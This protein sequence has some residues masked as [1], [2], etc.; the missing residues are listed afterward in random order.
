MW[1]RVQR[2]FGP[3]PKVDVRDELSFHLEMR[4]RELIERGESPERARELAMRRFG[5]YD[6]SRRECEAIDE[7][8]GRRMARTEYMTE[9][10][11]DIGYA[12]RTLRRTP[13]F[14]AVAVA[15][16]AL[17]IG[18][19]SAIFTVVHG[20]LLESLPF[21]NAERLHH[22]RMLYPDG[23][24]YLHVSA[25]DF[26]SVREEN[27]VFEQV[28]AYSTGILTMLGNG[29]PREIRGASVSDGL[30]PMLGVPV[31]LGRG[32]LPEENQS[33]RDRVVVLDNGF[34]RRA[35]G[36]DPAVLGRSVVIGGERYGIVGVLAPGAQLPERVGV[37]RRRL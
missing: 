12:V 6:E 15:T 2:V 14:T 3:N 29:E 22:V 33:G 35:F 21:R 37:V 36:G 24:T 16:L 5:D 34:W 4:I 10:R 30:L 26:V 17:G 18:A 31:A 32:F 23:T 28:E 9:L 25:P 1:K 20:V 13:G 19:N 27:R 8:R 11:Q 7:R